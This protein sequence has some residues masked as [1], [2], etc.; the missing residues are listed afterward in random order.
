MK[1]LIG[2]T[3]ITILILLVFAQVA[4]AKT[5]NGPDS[6]N[7]GEYT[8]TT[9]FDGHACLPNHTAG[10]CPGHHRYCLALCIPVECPHCKLTKCP[11]WRISIEPWSD[12]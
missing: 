7:R 11:H 5:G 12:G 1:K 3:V 4:V 6:Q 8:V 9:E 2:A 10:E